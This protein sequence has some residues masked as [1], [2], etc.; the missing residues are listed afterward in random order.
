MDQSLKQKVLGLNQTVCIENAL[1]RFEIDKTHFSDIIDEGFLIKKM[2][3]NL[4]L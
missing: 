2:E 4:S 1:L 3:Y